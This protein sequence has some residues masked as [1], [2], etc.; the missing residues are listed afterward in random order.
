MYYT[1]RKRDDGFGAIFQNIIFDILYAEYHNYKY[2][3]TPILSIDHN[4]NN[5]PEFTTKL[6]KFMNLADT[7]KCPENSVINYMNT[8]DFWTVDAELNKYCKINALNKIKTAFFSDKTSPFNKE[9]LNV[10]I[11]I[12]RPNARDNRIE[13]TDT[14]NSYYLNIINKIRNNNKDK[15][16]KFHIYSQGSEENFSEF[17]SNDTEF[18]LNGSVEDT[19]LGLVYGDTLVI[20]ASSLSYTAGLLSNGIVYYKPFWHPPLD[21]WVKDNSSIYRMSTLRTILESNNI[22]FENDKI[23]IK[24]N[25]KHIKFDIGLSYGAP[26]TQNWLKNENDLLV[27]GFEPNPTS[28]ADIKSPNNSKRHPCHGELLENKYINKSAFIIPIALGLN[29]DFLDFYITS[30]DVGCS[31]LYKPKDLNVKQTIKVPVFKLYDFFELLPLDTINYIEYIKIDAQG[32]DLDIL[33]SAANYISDKVVFVTLEAESGVYIG[34]EHNN[35]NNIS[36]YMNS[37]GFQRINHPN[38]A[39]PTYVNSKFINESKNIFISQ[40]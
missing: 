2:V 3:F 18:H 37:I 28:V 4:Y 20:S 32:S 33:K 21:S 24:S 25:V 5:D 8:S 1:T 40:L 13:G 38:T 12:R 9:H 10:S 31:S 19:F 6:N 15:S 30:N 26:Q 23:K 17:K 36:A 16:I 7:F 34:V 35:E 29:N 22:E 27:F 11:H 39:D 14:P